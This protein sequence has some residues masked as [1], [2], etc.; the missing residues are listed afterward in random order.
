MCKV[1]KKL[2]IKLKTMSLN[3]R[4]KLLALTNSCDPCVL[5]QELH[6]VSIFAEVDSNMLQCRY[7]LS[8]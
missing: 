1:E 7:C 4:T 3:V 5:P 2:D 8:L 6:L